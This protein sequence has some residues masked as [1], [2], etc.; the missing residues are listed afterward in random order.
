MRIELLEKIRSLLLPFALGQYV[1]DWQYRASEVSTISDISILRMRETAFFLKENCSADLTFASL[2]S[3]RKNIVTDFDNFSSL[4]K[5]SYSI[6]YN[7]LSNQEYDIF[8]E[9]YNEVDSSE[10][11]VISACAYAICNLSFPIEIV[12][13]LCNILYEEALHLES[14]SRLLGIDQSKKKWISND[15]CNHWNLVLNTKSIAEYFFL[16]HCLYE[17][18]GFIAAA[19]GV[20][21][22]SKYSEHSTGYKI[23]RL[24]FEQETNH[25]LTGYF[26]LKQ[27]DDITLESTLKSVL[28][29]FLQIEILTDIETFKGKRQRFPLLLLSHYLSNKSYWGI[30][31]LIME[32]ANSMIMTGNMSVTNEQL[33]NATEFCSRFCK[34]K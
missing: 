19:K 20:H 8:N 16:E 1:A 30:Q 21:E 32:N 18:R 5:V 6:D 25:V 22:L 15:K 14:I 33:I 7:L 17:G 3:F 24:I 29:Q 26:W 11:I 12:L 4:N 10:R 9:L 31:K 28:S 2:S 34:Y 23:A 27:L 13:V